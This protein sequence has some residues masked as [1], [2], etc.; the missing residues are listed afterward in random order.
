MTYS[1]IRNSLQNDDYIRENSFTLLR[2]ISLLINSKKNED[3][4]RELLI[5]VL[6]KRN[7]FQE[8]LDLIYSL[9]RSTGLFPYLNPESNE[10]SALDAFT[11]EMHRPLNIDDGFVFYSMQFK[12]YQEI[13]NGKNIVLSAST[14]VGKSLI[15]DALI[16]SKRYQTMVLVVPTIAL[17][18]ETRHRI[19]KRF[20]KECK[21]ITHP[22]QVKQKSVFN[23]YI[24]T[25]ERVIERTDLENVDIFVIDEFYKLDFKMAEDDRA[26]A[27]NLALYKLLHCSKQFFLIG[28]NIDYVN[29]L[30]RLGYEFLFIPSAFSTVAVNITSFDF[31]KNDIERDDKL[32]EICSDA[33]DPVLIY[34]QSPASVNKIAKLML[35]KGIK[36]SPSNI[37]DAL[38]WIDRH[39]SKDWIFYQALSNGIGIHHGGIPRALQQ[40][41]L[42]KFN[43]KTLKYLICTST[44]IEGVNT[45]AKNVIV[46]DKR[47]NSRLLDYFTYKNIEGRAGRMGQYFVGNVFSLESPPAKEI[48][49]VDIAIASQGANTPVNLL[50]HMDTVDLSEDSKS[51]IKIAIHEDILS[52]VTVKQNLAYS[53][54]TQYNLANYLKDN[55]ETLT[56]SFNWKSFPTNDQLREICILIFDF[57]EGSRLKNFNI[58]SGIDL[59]RHV[60]MLMMS[61]GVDGYLKARIENE[62]SGGDISDII[63]NSLKIVRNVFCFSFPRA[64]RSLDNIQ[65][66]VL[67][68]NGI[69]NVGDFNN[70]A[71]NVENLKMEPDLFAL[72]EFGIP[73]QTIE[74]IK[75]RFVNAADLD[76][77]LIILQKL[78]YAN[79][80]LLKF[81]RDIID[82]FKKDHIGG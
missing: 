16:A 58:L 28:P 37:A 8:H 32:I 70:Y 61:E 29:N 13:L 40:Y 80:D 50:L 22:S 39:Y 30:T 27:L 23:I 19:I 21:I 77:C 67:S 25:Q 52:T 57:L 34:C 44:I 48:S 38:E 63:E 31:K 9:I 54:E 10:L 26:T 3:L 56:E 49:Q 24:L 78:D 42:S 18:D 55:L 7:L 43:D 62:S 79:F 17:I 74:K 2:E 59:D 6:D 11:F 47:N 45:V 51:R 14:S 12:I 72:N 15:I 75:D 68:K 81:E 35:E 41:C 82:N 76:Q 33:N 4:G 73:L 64:L 1:T 53:P 71:S 20:N 69:D 36:G 66:E 5:R 65:K 60:K 46:Y